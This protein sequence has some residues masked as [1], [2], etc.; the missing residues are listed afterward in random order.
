M[1]L[2]FFKLMNWIFT[3]VYNDLDTQKVK[4]SQNGYIMVIRL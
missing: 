4:K 3:F 2:N 1:F